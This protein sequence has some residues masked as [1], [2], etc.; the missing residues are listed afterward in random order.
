[1]KT[2]L[3]K[4]LQ[5]ADSAEVYVR[6]VLSTSVDLLKGEIQEVASEIKTEVSLRIVKNGNMGTAVATDIMDDTL[7]SRAVISL[8]NQ[9]SEAVPF[10]NLEVPLVLCA[11]PEVEA[12]TT[13]Q[14]V[15]IVT[16]VSQRIVEQAPDV[17]TGISA[18]KLVK[19]VK[20]LNSTGFE[21]SYL[22]TNLALGMSTKTAQGFYGASKSY[23]GAGLPDVT[24]Q[25]ITQMLTLHRLG[26]KPVT[27]G[28]ERM[29]VIF[30]GSVMGA[31]MMRVLGGVHGGNV[32]KEISPLNGK[33]GERLFSD[34]ITIVD[35][36]TMAYGCNSQPFDD[37]GIPCKRTVLYEKGVLKNYLVSIGQSQ[38]LEMPATGN[39]IKRA[40]FS[41]EIEDAPSVFETNFLIEG[42]SISDEALIKGVK[43]G[44]YITGVM[45]AHTGNINGGEFSLNI[46]SGYLIE[47]GHLV[48]QV[49]GCMIAGNIYDLFRNIQAIGTQQEVMHSI[50]Y[51][52]G[53]SPMV[54]FSE[55]NII[56]K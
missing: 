40:L 14:L 1:M 56:G 17:T 37:E 15:D 26:E 5:V 30:G 42:E 11:T 36:G 10:P 29:P 48:G 35:D 43:R 28:N 39:A 34:K 38:K 3:Q 50:F 21:Q 47:E 4:A 33:I 55:A 18:T 6:D 22:Y 27:L 31:L 20:M 2:V 19:T 32:S 41:K 46:S 53:Y 45:G 16:S 12:L 49:K 7:I 13:Q 44:L 25:H 52:M 23:S 9:K 24:D 51:H 54:L 8:E